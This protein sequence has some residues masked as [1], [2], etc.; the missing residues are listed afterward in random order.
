MDHF[1]ELNAEELSAVQGAGIM[2]D[3]MERF[4][5]GEWVGNS[6]YPNG[7]PEMPAPTSPVIW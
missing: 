4:P 1:E 5:F 3:L 6:F 7:A 2:Q